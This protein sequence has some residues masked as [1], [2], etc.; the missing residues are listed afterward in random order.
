MALTVIMTTFHDHRVLQRVQ[1]C[2]DVCLTHHCRTVHSEEHVFVVTKVFSPQAYICCDK[3]N[4]RDTWFATK[5]LSLCCNKY[6]SQQK[7]CCNKNMSWQKFCHDKHTFVVT[8]DMFSLFKT[9][10]N[11]NNTRMGPGLWR[12]P[13]P[14]LSK[15]GPRKHSCLVDVELHHVHVLG[16]QLTY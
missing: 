15:V 7:F 5:L 12:S 2:S 1:F 16:Y 3:R 6:L 13:V 10:H 14:I 4:V 9:R 8:K 11:R